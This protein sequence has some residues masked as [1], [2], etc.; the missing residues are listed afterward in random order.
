MGYRDRDAEEA[1]AMFLLDVPKAIFLKSKEAFP[2]DIRKD[3][4][5]GYRY[6]EEV[7]VDMADLSLDSLNKVYEASKEIDKGFSRKL[8]YLINLLEDPDDQ[9]VVKKVA[10]LVLVLRAYFTRHRIDGW[11][12]VKGDSGEPLAYALTHM[13]Y[14]P[15]ERHGKELYPD[16]VTLQGVANA[17]GRADAFYTSF[18]RHDLK[19][20]IQEVLLSKGIFTETQKLK[21]QYLRATSNYDKHV[22]QYAKQFTVEGS[23]KAYSHD[24]EREHGGRHSWR[25]RSR[26][27]EY[28]LVRTSEGKK[29]RVLVV[30]DELPKG[31]YQPYARTNVF[32][33]GVAPLKKK[34]PVQQPGGEVEGDFI[35]DEEEETVGRMQGQLYRPFHPYV[36]C[37]ALDRQDFL[38]I[39]ANDL[40]P[41][42][43]NKSLRGKLILPESH[44]QLI[45]ALV[46]DLEVFREDLIA[47]KAGGT[48]ILC[49]GAPGL[50]KTLTAEVY[51]EITER[52]LYKV[53][54]GQ[55]GVEHAELET[56]LKLVM[57][58]ADR[59]K[60]ALL[61]D[62]ADVYIRARGDDLEQNAVVASF[63]RTM[64]YFNGLLFLTT[65]RGDEIDDAIA[66]RCVAIVKYEKPNEKDCKRLWKVLSDHYG[67]KLT[68]KLIEELYDQFKGIPG[69]D[70]KNLVR[71]TDRYSRA[72]EVP[73]DLEAFKV[74]G[75]FRNL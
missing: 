47:G 30:E 62:E 38:W 37:F 53:H 67:V 71:L 69:R 74:C 58:R 7:S 26:S 75:M 31:A 8:A 55:L 52:P 36:Y 41:Y 68:N 65:N 42:A 15:P 40:E 73:L 61:I 46:K 51:S 56:Q 70:I 59:W 13:K 57:A 28:D 63:L 24:S 10:G 49:Q 14:H 60:V 2:E 6:A 23:L 20:T 35:E 44:E 4:T 54:S 34:E 43:Y 25:S 64:E 48:V 21:M 3:F 11:F 72:R 12:Y 27:E 17:H 9:Q 39:H 18:Y 50:G 19:G 5:E 33:D 32:Q 16:Y 66:S 29:H 22:S 45:D 1:G